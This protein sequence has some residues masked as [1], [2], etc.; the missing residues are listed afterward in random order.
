MSRNNSGVL[1]KI[2]V[3]LALLWLAGLVVTAV[4]YLVLTSSNAIQAQFASSGSQDYA[5]YFTAQSG[6]TLGST[7]MGAGVLGLLLALAAHAV[8]RPVG[9]ADSMSA[10]EPE[11]DSFDDELETT[12]P[13]GNDDQNT[14]SNEAAAEPA[15]EPTT[16]R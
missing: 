1:A 10:T 5:T 13:I 3:P 8:T 7:L 14:G 16:T 6:S 9:I 12:G 4:G 2:N 15:L 11:E